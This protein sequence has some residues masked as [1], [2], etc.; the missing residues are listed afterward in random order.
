MV[1]DTDVPPIPRKKWYR[2]R[3]IVLAIVLLFAISA[4]YGFWSALTARPE[5]R[6]DYSEELLALA[7]RAQSHATTENGWSA[8]LDALNQQ[9]AM[10]VAL[11]DQGINVD[12]ADGYLDFSTACL[13]PPDPQRWFREEAAIMAMEDAGAFDYTAAV[14]EF[15][16]FVKPLVKGQMLVMILLPELGQARQLVRAQM[17]RARRAMDLGDHETA[18]KAFEESIAISRA[19]GYQPILINQLVHIACMNLITEH[20]HYALM[21]EQ[22]DEDTC[23][24]LLDILSSPHEPDTTLG[25]QG[26]RFMFLDIVQRIYTDNGRGNGRLILSEF[27]VQAALWGMGAGQFLGQISQHPIANVASIAFASRKETVETYNTYSDD[28]IARCAMTMIERQD[29]PPA[30]EVETLTM[31]DMVLKNLMPALDRIPDQGSIHR[32]NIDG[33]RILCALAAH[34][35]RHGA[36]PDTLDA[37]VPTYLDAIP[38]DP[39][40]GK[41]FIYR[42]L[43]EPD[44]AGRTILLY[45]FGEDGD[46]DNGREIEGRWGRPDWDGDR[47]IG[48]PRPEV[49]DDYVDERETADTG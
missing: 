12:S 10:K 16:L 26:E 34:R 33:T 49:P 21:S 47:V 1:D 11:L 44:D 14:T 46:D 39:I 20:M 45:S 27:Q 48:K 22:L 25:L 32:F 40:T 5:V 41:A 8:V 37:L 3:N 4:G 13:G 24:A 23:L 43:L 15:D 17:Y 2:P 30:F 31:R 38:T 29:V 42:R 36:Y 35:A 18:R 19:L 6:V 28:L 7:T 9:E